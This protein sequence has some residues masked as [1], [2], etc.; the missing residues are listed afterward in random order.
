MRGTVFIAVGQPTRPRTVIP[1][2]LNVRRPLKNRIRL[3]RTPWIV[4][5]RPS[6]WAPTAIKQSCQAN[7]K[8]EFDVASNPNSG[9]WPRSM[10][11]MRPNPWLWTQNER[12][13]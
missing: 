13:D 9:E 7:P 1:I 8:A 6:L 4:T 3:N 10:N 2:Y 5:N 12:A 11:F